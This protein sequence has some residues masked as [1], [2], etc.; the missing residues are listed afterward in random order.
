MRGAAA[1]RMR[2][3]T[4]GEGLRQAELDCYGQVHCHGFSVERRGLVLPC[5]RASMA[6]CCSSV[7][8]ETTFM[9]VTRSVGVDQ[10]VDHDAARNIWFLASVG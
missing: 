4:N 10:R 1:L 8:P 6:A 5:F 2:E 3:M 7:G 9:V